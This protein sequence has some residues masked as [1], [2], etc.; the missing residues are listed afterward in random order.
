MA[1]WSYSILWDGK[2]NLVYLPIQSLPLSVLP[3]RSFFQ[4]PCVSSM[5]WSEDPSW[6]FQHVE[7]PCFTEN[8]YEK[9]WTYVNTI[10]TLRIIEIAIQEYRQVWSIT[11]CLSIDMLCCNHFWIQRKY[12][13]TGTWRFSRCVIFCMPR[14]TWSTEPFQ[15]GWTIPIE[16]HQYR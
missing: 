7:R 3:S 8:T 15:L 16:E 14:Q 2:A 12:M 6:M 5:T 1:H 10:P 11:P 9:I 4:A 13:R